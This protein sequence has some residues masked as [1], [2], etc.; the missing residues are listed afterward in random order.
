MTAPWRRRL[1]R[2]APSAVQ[3]T[4]S[5]PVGPGRERTGVG[6]GQPRLSGP[7]V[8]RTGCIWLMASERL[9]WEA[10]KTRIKG[11]G[12]GRSG[13]RGVRQRWG[14]W[15]RSG[16][17]PSW[18]PGGEGASALNSQRRAPTLQPLRF[19]RPRGAHGTSRQGSAAVRTASGA[20]R[21][22]G[23][24]RDSPPR[25]STLGRRT[26]P[27]QHRPPPRTPAGLSLAQFR[28][29]LTKAACG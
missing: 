6:S 2:Q 27:G 15:N 23:H 17:E 19:L 3:L 12:R 14:P 10:Q 11:W 24:L 7:P 5:G 4:V 20:L 8:A 29:D 9:A 1:E 21:L 13:A 18:A 26:D 22:T 28:L 16:D 25:L